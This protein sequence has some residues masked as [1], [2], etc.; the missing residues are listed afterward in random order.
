MRI[1]VYTS[2]PIRILLAVYHVTRQKHMNIWLQDYIH[3]LVSA[4]WR[5][6]I[7]QLGPVLCSEDAV[8]KSSLGNMIQIRLNIQETFFTVYVVRH[9]NRMPKEVVNATSLELF[10]TRFDETLRN[11]I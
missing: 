9:W 1:N 10:K 3:C 6:K 2:I 5:E 4:T 7:K 11:L 8:G